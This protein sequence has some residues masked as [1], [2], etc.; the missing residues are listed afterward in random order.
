MDL[1]PFV[2]D[3]DV[4]FFSSSKDCSEIVELWVNRSGDFYAKI[5]CPKDN[6]TTINL[7]NV[8]LPQE[9]KRLG[10]KVFKAQSTKWIADQ[11]GNK[12]PILKFGS[13]NSF[14]LS[15]KINGRSFERKGK[16]RI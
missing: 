2:D 1:V 8:D 5:T 3:N 4:V 11:M 9:I 16:F 7:G 14:Y 12:F 6:V 15:F 10:K 13:G